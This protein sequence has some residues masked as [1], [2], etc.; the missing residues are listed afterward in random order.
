MPVY[1]ESTHYLYSDA[2][3]IILDC[4]EDKVSTNHPIRVEAAFIVDL[5]T[6]DDDDE[7][8]S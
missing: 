7:Y 4:A 5:S 1:S 8:A 6:D 3:K 2:V